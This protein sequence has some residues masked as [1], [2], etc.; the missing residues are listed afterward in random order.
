VRR[1]RIKPFDV[2]TRVCTFPKH[3][4][5]LLRDVPHDYLVW[6][7]CH[8]EMSV[9]LENAIVEILFANRGEKP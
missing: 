5:A 9:L 6:I 2:Q 1:I 8:V 3:R 4:G 7:L